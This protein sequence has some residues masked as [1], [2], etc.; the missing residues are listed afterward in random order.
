MTVF[1]NVFDLKSKI[2]S[3]HLIIRLNFVLFIGLAV[4][5][6]EIVIVQN[7]RRFLLTLQNSGF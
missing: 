5:K 3:P 7:A 4:P 2:L 1:D 6:G